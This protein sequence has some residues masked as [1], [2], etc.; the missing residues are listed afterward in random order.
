MK[1]FA[2]S[3]LILTFTPACWLAMQVVHEAGH[4]LA[5]R[6]TGGQVIKVAL[7][8]L[9]LS[10][11]VLGENPHPLAVV[12]AG[13]LVGT[14]LPLLMFGLA[15]AARLP[16]VYLFRFFAGFCLVANGVYIG[17]GAWLSEEADPWVMTENGSPVWLLVLFGL[18]AAPLGLYLWHRQGPHFGLGEA[19]G[20]VSWGAAVTSTMLLVV[21]IGAEVL[22]SGGG[23]AAT[24]AGR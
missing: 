9:I 17:I 18:L 24:A 16:G 21:V 14:V 20:K 3:L 5:A 6:S 13:P 4:V 22:H 10:Q 23:A 1:R 15:V 12:W 11:T 7:H 8:P 2:Q 19:K